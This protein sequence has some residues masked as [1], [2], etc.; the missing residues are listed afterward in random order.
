[1]PINTL[2]DKN[3]VACTHNGILFSLE[4]EKKPAICDNMNEP[5]RLYAKSKKP[6]GT[7]N[8]L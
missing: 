6:D 3:N 1:M 7:I 4:K 8:I 5:G 2:I